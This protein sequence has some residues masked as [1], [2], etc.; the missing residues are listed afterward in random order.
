M[1]TFLPKSIAVPRLAGRTPSAAAVVT[2]YGRR[3][4]PS[5]T[6]GI[7][8]CHRGCRNGRCGG[9]PRSSS[10]PPTGDPRRSSG[11][12]TR[13]FGRWWPP[14]ALVLIFISELVK[15]RWGAAVG[16][17][18]IVGAVIRW[19]WPREAPMTVEEEDDFEREYGVPVNAHGSVVVA[20]WAR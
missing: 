19:N 14:L 9:G 15:L 13:R 17:L 12:R 6:R 18:V 5:R 4:P 16:A 10:A 7:P 11:S 20:A 1:R 8:R 3:L 2:C